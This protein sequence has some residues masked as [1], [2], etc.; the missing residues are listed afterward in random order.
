MVLALFALIYLVLLR[1]RER[2][3]LLLYKYLRLLA[4][5]A[6][7]TNGTRPLLLLAT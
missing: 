7:T 5:F 4:L 2:K 3:F 6:F 1:E